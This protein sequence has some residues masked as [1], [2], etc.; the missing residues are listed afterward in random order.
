MY[1]INSHGYWLSVILSLFLVLLN[2]SGCS[3]N[4]T[5]NPNNVARSEKSLVASSA[6]TGSSSANNNAAISRANSNSIA[7]RVRFVRTPGKVQVLYGQKPVTN[8]LFG[9]KLA[10]PVLYPLYAPDGII[11]TRGYPFRNVPGESHDHPHHAG[12]FFTYDNVNGHGFWN[13]PTP[14]PQI[15]LNKI[16]SIKSTANHATLSTQMSWVT[17]N[18]VTLL[19]EYRTMI[20]TCTPNAYT[21]DFLITLQADKQKVVFGDTKEGMFAIRVADWLRETGG[22]GHYI[23]ST[24][25]KSAKQIWGK[26]AKWVALQGNKDGK[27]IG[28]AIFNL[29]GSVNFPTYWHARAYGLFAANPLGQY[30]FQKTRNLKNP[31]YFNYTLKPNQKGHFFFRVIIYNGHYNAQKLN[32]DYKQYLKW[33]QKQ[34]ILPPADFPRHT[35]A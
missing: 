35:G 26:R 3:Q 11:V 7:N 25:S 20:F 24:G 23:A 4:D 14:P 6:L 19:H 5:D 22:T 31:K 13:K 34:N 28:I 10:K 15:K 9:S 27:D 12:L 18:G 1:R 32:E 17:K 8:L 2:I 33:A 30:V 29:P 16:T 21:I